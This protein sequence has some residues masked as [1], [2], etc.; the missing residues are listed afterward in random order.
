MLDRLHRGGVQLVTGPDSG[1]SAM[2]AHGKLAELIEFLAE[3][4]LSPAASLAAATSQAAQACGVGSRK[5]MLRRGY[6]ADLVV[7]DGDPSTDPGAL[8]NVRSVVLGGT[9]VRG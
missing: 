5:G 3:A 7:V 9:V 1:I 6:D 8:C 4:G 2:V